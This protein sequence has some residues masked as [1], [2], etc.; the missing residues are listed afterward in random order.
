M[1]SGLLRPRNLK[2]TQSLAISLFVPFFVRKI[3]RK[4]FCRNPRGIFPTEFPGEFCRGF[5]GG[6]F[7]GLFPWKKQ[8]EKI[9]PKIHGN[10]QIGVW[11]F[12]GQ[13]PHCKDPALTFWLCVGVRQ[14]IAQKGVRATEAESRNQ[15][16]QKRCKSQCSRS[17]AVNRSV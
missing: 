5:F 17:W 2:T 9:H 16:W 11:E 3:S 4:G 14:G 13:N 8:E 10:F 6:F 1:V 15:K 12:R 7:S